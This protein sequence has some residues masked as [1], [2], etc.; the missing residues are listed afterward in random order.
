ME[1]KLPVSI[2]HLDGYDDTFMHTYI[3]MLEQKDIE[4]D[5]KQN[6]DQDIVYTI[7]SKVLDPYTDIETLLPEHYQQYILYV[8][9]KNPG[10]FKD[11]LYQLLDK[12]PIEA[13][14]NVLDQLIKDELIEMKKL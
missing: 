7:K 14:N 9:N 5:I 3:D 11:K 13:F 6:Q 8:I 10:I 2:A 1:Y 4:I 12:I